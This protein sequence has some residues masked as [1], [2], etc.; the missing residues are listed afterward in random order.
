MRERKRRCC[1]GKPSLVR[2]TSRVTPFESMKHP[3]KTAKM[4]MRS[5]EDPLKGVVLSVSEVEGGGAR[6]GESSHR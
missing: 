3:I 5:K 4:I 2:E 1:T 6:D